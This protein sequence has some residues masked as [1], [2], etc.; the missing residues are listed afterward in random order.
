MVSSGGPQGDV[1]SQ[2]VD[3]DEAKQGVKFGASTPIGWE[4]I[5]ITIGV[6]TIKSLSTI[7]EKRGT[8][9]PGNSGLFQGSGHNF[10]KSSWK[11]VRIALS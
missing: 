7:M 3:L 11:R 2:N 4:D 5:P 9:P 8:V 1:T 6:S 10:Y